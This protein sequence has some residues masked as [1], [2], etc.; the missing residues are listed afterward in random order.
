MTASIELL[1]QDEPEVAAALRAMTAPD[2]RAMSVALAEHALEAVGL[3]EHLPL[4]ST[5]PGRLRRAR[6][7]AEDDYWRLHGGDDDPGPQPGCGE[8]FARERALAAACATLGDDPLTSAAG[9]FY[10]ASFA[11]DDRAALRA[12]LRR[13][14]P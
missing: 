9:A 12:F 10:E 1:E 4:S 6:D 2:L 11:V 7:T 5:D 8:A 3:A 13:T 14:A